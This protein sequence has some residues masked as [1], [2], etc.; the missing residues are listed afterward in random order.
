MVDLVK[1]R[2]KAKE[3]A[4]EKSGAPAPP[5]APGLAEPPAPQST[6][7]GAVAPLS[8]PESTTVTQ[9]LEQFLEHVGERRQI[10]DAPTLEAPRPKREVLTFVI[11]R[12][13]Y[14]VDIERVIEIVTLRPVTR[15]PNAEALVVGI[16]SLRGTVVTLLDIRRK[17]GH[18]RPSGAAADRRIIV[19]DHESEPIGFEVDLVLRVVKIDAD[20][21]EPHPVVH[22]S[23]ADEAVRGVFRH[24]DALTILLDFAKLLGSR[25]PVSVFRGRSAGMRAPGS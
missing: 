22:P 23:E 2:R 8:P 3:K 1:I 17:L 18:P 6:G 21:I 15:V 12:E 25:S 16:L 24:G 13:H 9:R 7:E 20:D 19:I 4:A 11:D 14:A 5:P 10:H